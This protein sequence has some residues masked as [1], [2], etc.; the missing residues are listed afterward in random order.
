MQQAAISP[1]MLAASPSRET[2]S[3]PNRSP[4]HGAQATVV[5]ERPISAMEP[6]T[7]PLAGFMTERFGNRDAGEVLHDHEGAGQADEDQQRPAVGHNLA[8]VGLNAEG[9][10]VVDEQQV[11]ADHVEG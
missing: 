9:G 11:A 4:N 7:M 10:E 1:V 3:S 2:C 8:Q 5:P 6:A